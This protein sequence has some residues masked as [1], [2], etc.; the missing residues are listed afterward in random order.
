MELPENT[1]LM[2]LA[3]SA[4]A[5]GA[6]PPVNHDDLF[7]KIIKSGF[8]RVRVDGQFLDLEQPPKLDATVPHD[9]EVVID[10][11]VIREDA[12]P[13]LAESLQLALK[14]GEGSVI[15]A[16]EN[17]T[18]ETERDRW[19]DLPFCVHY[20]C[21]H[22]NISYTELEPRTF[23]FNSPYGACPACEGTGCQ[24]CDGS[25]LRAEARNVTF[26][27]KRI[28]E[29]CALPIEEALEFFLSQR[30]EGHK[31]V[32]Q[33]ESPLCPSCLCAKQNIITETIIPQITSR[34]EF[35]CRIG[36]SYL[37]LSRTVDT[38]SGGELQRVRLA[39]GLGS[40]LTGVCYVLDEP[41]IGLH[42]RDNRRLIDSIK[43]LRE[44][45][46]TVLVVEHD[47]AVIREADYRIEIGP[48]SGKY[49]GELVDHRHSRAGGNLDVRLCSLDSRLRGNDGNCI[50]NENVLTLENVST[51]NLKNIT[52]S[53]PLQKLICVT[54]VSGSGKSSLINETLVPMMRREIADDRR[55]TAADASGAVAPLLPSA[56]CCLPSNSID[57]LI[58]VDQTPL[59]RSSR[60]NPATYSGLFDELRKLFASTKDAKR[61][62]YKASRF[63]F[64]AGGGRCETCQGLGT[65]KIEANFLNDYYAVC[66]SCNGKRFN[67][68]TLMV[69][70]KG[71]SM[72]DILEMPIE[73]AATFFANIPKIDRIL[74][75]MLRIGLGYLALGQPSSMLSGGESQRVKLATE[76]AKPET[77]KTLYVLDE[78]TTGLHRNDVL[79]LMD[80][81]TDLTTKGNT[82]IVIE[83]NLDAMARSD[84]LIDLGPEG[85]ECG[86]YILA[87]G[88]PADIAD[89]DDNATGKFLRQV[90]TEPAA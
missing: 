62:G 10:R 33:P 90:F 46:N 72:A 52:V 1:R 60:S 39:T 48:G 55:Q 23:S 83:H 29:I 49:G 3:P 30:H 44:R 81:L 50:S 13:R 69:K 80:V 5:G 40:G 27:E 63:S 16:V 41:T 54:G 59:G 14:H 84:W 45:G 19:N 11:L 65:Q 21:P 89:L 15:A 37:S 36:L 26:A 56:V 58:E 32:E 53:F 38:L 87:T 66:P 70:Y 20:A 6:S 75:A 22:C 34:L 79:R 24:V 43:E 4:R 74:Q 9:I 68:Q 25:R 51:H 82:V 17:K 71:K 86:G 2:L 18:A 77:G 85:G 88:T 76:L 78:P 8:F 64:N 61:R 12:R 47:D 57:K 28:Y 7:Q 73:E 67:R 42:P 35:L 31:E